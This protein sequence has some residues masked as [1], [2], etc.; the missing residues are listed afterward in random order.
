MAILVTEMRGLGEITPSPDFLTVQ[1][2]SETLR[3]LRASASNEVVGEGGG[4]GEFFAE[5]G[6]KM[7][8][9]AGG[10]ALGVLLAVLASKRKRGRGKRGRR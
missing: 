6:T 10:L 5:H 2:V 7:A 9:G 8:A 1:N 4:V 3:R